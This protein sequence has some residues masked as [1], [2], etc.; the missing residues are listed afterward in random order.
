MRGAN[1]IY[2]YRNFNSIS[3][4][5]CANNSELYNLCAAMQAKRRKNLVQAHN[6]TKHIKTVYG[7]I[8]SKPKSSTI[9]TTL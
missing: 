7:D 6:M 4:V 8:V 5:Y 3:V 2:S 1:N 9:H